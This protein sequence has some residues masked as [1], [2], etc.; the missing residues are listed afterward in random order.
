MPKRIAGGL[1]LWLALF[2]LNVWAEEWSKTFELNGKADLRIETNDARVQVE[3]WERKEIEAHVISEGVRIGFW[4]GSDD[5]RV[6]CAISSPEIASSWRS[7]SPTR[8][9]SSA[10]IPGP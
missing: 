5:H 6:R 1:V 8:A 10:S 2:S 9:G 4:G 7:A 3:A